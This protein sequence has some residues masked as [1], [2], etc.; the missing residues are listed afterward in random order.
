MW[1]VR[2]TPAGPLSL[3][4]KYLKLILISSAAGCLW[5]SAADETAGKPGE[6]TPQRS[7]CL[8]GLTEAA[9]ADPGQALTSSESHAGQVL[10]TRG[11]VILHQPS[12]MT[13]ATSAFVHQNSDAYLSGAALSCSLEDLPDLL[14]A[15]ESCSPDFHYPLAPETWLGEVQA[16]REKHHLLILD[17]RATVPAMRIR[18]AGPWR[19]RMLQ[20]WI[21]AIIEARHSSR[22]S[23]LAL[24]DES[25]TTLTSEL[26][27]RLSIPLL[28][29]RS[30]N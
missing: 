22:V 16:N 10:L 20:R 27:H 29:R 28:Q 5:L 13:E 26:S 14:S 23:I 11:G 7:L 21:S 4:Y 18:G 9:A 6:S 3:M 1:Y 24:A 30:Q 15:L 17:M 19:K 2:G 25:Q 12:L 8:H